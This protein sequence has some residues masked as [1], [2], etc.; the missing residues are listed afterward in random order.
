VSEP[1]S[2]AGGGDFPTP[3]EEAFIVIA[4]AIA[5]GAAVDWGPGA[6]GGSSPV[7]TWLQRLDLIARGFQRLRTDDAAD[8]PAAAETILS[9]AR[10]IA[11]SQTAILT[12][13]WGPLIVLEKIGRGSFGD[14]YRAW[15]PR[16]DREVALKIVPED[17]SQDQ[18]S[19]AIDEARRLAR[20]RHPNVLTVFGAERI[21]GR[22]GIWTEFLPGATLASIVEQQGPLPVEAAA[23]AGVL[24]CRALAAV[25]AAGLLHRDVKAHNVLR[26]PSGRIALS[27]FGTSVELPANEAV[28]EARIA[29]TP[30]YLAPEVLQGQPP[31]VASDLYSLG[32]LLFYLVT[33]EYPVPGRT[34]EEI[35]RAH[36]SDRRVRLAERRLA[37]PLEFSSVVE[38]LLE[39]DP[40]HRF[41]NAS[42]VEAAL[43][44]VDPTVTSTR[45]WR[46][47]A[48]AATV[49]A[50][51]AGVWTLLGGGRPGGER[52]RLRPAGVWSPREISAAT[53]LSAIAPSQDGRWITCVTSDGSLVR[54]SPATGTTEV[55]VAGRQDRRID[56]GFLS[57]DG[58]QVAYMIGPANSPPTEIHLLDLGTN[59]DRHIANV[60]D[61]LTYL[62]L[63][64]W[65]RDGQL[66]FYALRVAGTGLKGSLGLMDPNVGAL[67]IAFEFPDLPQRSE[68]S[69]DGD[70][71]AFD[72]LQDDGS[73]ARDVQ[74]CDLRSHACAAVASHPAHDFNPVWT[75][76][77]RL[78]FNSDR[79]GTNGLWI[80]SIDGLRASAP[81]RLVDL[82]R[83]LVWPL[84]FTET[85][86]LFFSQ[87][88]A[89]MDVF[90]AEIAGAGAGEQP[91]AIR[92]S[93]RLIGRNK[94]PV[95]SADGRSLAY[96]AQRGPFADSGAIRVVV[97]VWPSQSEREFAFPMPFNS[98]R[99]AWSPDGRFLA[100]QA[101]LGVRGTATGGIHLINVADGRLLTTLVGRPVAE[102][103]FLDD[104][105]I[106]F[107]DD[108]ALRTVDSVTATERLIWQAPPG[109]NIRGLA[110]SPDGVSL[111]VLLGA[112]DQTWSALTVLPSSGGTPRE[113]LRRHDAGLW[114]PACGRTRSSDH[115]T[116]HT[117]RHCGWRPASA[118]VAHSRRRRP[119]GAPAAG[120]RG[121][122]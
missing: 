13:R 111:G 87:T 28:V 24:L 120:G 49:V 15:D 113:I 80:T 55:L 99:L 42:A 84:G 43:S 73:G 89:E 20:I 40:N 34:L 14:V 58:R 69:P 51:I 2:V 76:D 39:P 35:R 48:I 82:G 86:D 106:A 114:A 91:A 98:S 7:A 63:S 67:E 64:G 109:H 66:H 22:V 74:V 117:G 65:Q 119:A 19:P 107:Q 103:V 3:D 17:A 27:D 46:L 57:P 101:M 8:D 44:P 96:I 97:Q 29:G 77:G 41:E 23:S 112:Q 1:D 54:M 37:V 26:D 31:S 108:S 121:T 30:L 122:L 95:W 21:N 104:R 56:A 52:N 70:R 88:R 85:G 38:R 59:V 60:P 102:T 25:H 100:L 4:A 94:A 10:R 6:S 71:L 9:E 33:G 5:D 78:I 83:T 116:R 12:I 93:P 72:L 81:E 62:K 61:G 75:P 11:G 36:A 92:L 105:T 68:R 53:C 18:A 90:S 118:I 110:A 79:L 45:F 16:L 50:A 47:A 115:S 32:V